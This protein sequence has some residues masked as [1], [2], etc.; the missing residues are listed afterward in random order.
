M[1]KEHD[2]VQRNQ[3]VHPSKLE[4][5]KLEPR[6]TQPPRNDAKEQRGGRQDDQRT[7]QT[8]KGARTQNQ[9]KA[10]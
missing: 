1:A 7:G 3:W 6:E 4:P 8:Q 9:G 2:T 5:D 10:G